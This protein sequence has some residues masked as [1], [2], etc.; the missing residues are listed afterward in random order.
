[1]KVRTIFIT[2]TSHVPL[3]SWQG[4]HD[5]LIWLI[6]WNKHISINVVTSLQQVN[7]CGLTIS[8]FPQSLI[9]AESGSPDIYFV[10]FE[11]TCKFLGQHCVHS[12]VHVRIVYISTFKFT[13]G[14]SEGSLISNPVTL[15]HVSHM[16]LLPSIP[17]LCPRPNELRPHLVTLVPV[18]N[19]IDAL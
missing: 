15:V 9:W 17:I 11:R 8:T 18:I 14:F 16:W 1:M 7:S 2:W 19:P 13:N 6:S 12:C 3:R 5:M 10:I 4:I